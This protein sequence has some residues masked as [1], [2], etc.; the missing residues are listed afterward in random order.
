[1][2]NQKNRLLFAILTAQKTSRRQYVK[3]SVI[4]T[5]K[6]L[7]FGVKMIE[8]CEASLN[9]DDTDNNIFPKKTPNHN[10]TS[11]KNNYICTQ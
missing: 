3:N 5:V 9:A 8:F 1:M 6:I 10:N 2:K 4:K 11:T 7:S